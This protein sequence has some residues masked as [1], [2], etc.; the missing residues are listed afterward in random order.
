MGGRVTAYRPNKILFMG[1]KVRSSRTSILILCL[2]HP[3]R[4]MV[5]WNKYHKTSLPGTLLFT[6]SYPSLGSY[7]KAY[8][9]M[10]SLPPE[11]EQLFVLPRHKVDSSILKQGWEHEEQAHCHPNVNGFHIG[12]LEWGWG[13]T[14][15]HEGRKEWNI[16]I[17]LLLSNSPI[18][19]CYSLLNWDIRKV[20]R[21][22]RKMHQEDCTKHWR[23]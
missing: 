3:L 21:K 14:P 6:T 7:P 19:P 9:V 8:L 16:S 18:T 22:T 23:K 10:S 12:H 13:R 5:Q 11:S 1:G 17:F 15:G 4:R 2:P 20:Q